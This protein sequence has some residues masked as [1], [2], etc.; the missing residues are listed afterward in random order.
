MVSITNA[1]V[2]LA[3]DL[4]VK[5]YVDTPVNEIIVEHKKV[6]GIKVKG[7]FLPFDTVVSN[8]DVTHTYRKLL[9]TQVHPNRLLNQ[10]KSSSGI[11]FYWGIKKQFAALGLHNILFSDDYR[12]EFK[13]MFEDKT[14]THDPTIYINITAKLKPD[15]A[16]EGC[17]NW[18]VLINA[19]ANE[20][21]NWDE[22]IAQTRKNVIAKITRILGQDI[23][24]LIECEDVLDPRS[25]ET[26]TSS[27]QGALY[28]NSSNNRYAAF[29]RHAN[30]S[31]KIKNL[32]F[33]GGSV[34]PGGGI[35]LAIS[36][37][38]IACKYIQ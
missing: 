26:K 33:V 36:S 38:K 14:I 18:F 2:A 22:I 13:T 16:P 10:P 35:P 27:A 8:M 6:T 17:E 20:G 34:H 30:F 5:F 9:P 32:Y 28:G 4:G 21:Q 1:L 23:T 12:A 25:I 31:S 15:D 24:D 3:Q 11:I 29:L 37:A 7:S 19:P